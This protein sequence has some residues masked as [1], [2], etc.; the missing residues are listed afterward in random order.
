LAGQEKGSHLRDNHLGYPMRS[1]RTGDYLYIRNFRP[2]RWP[3][4]NPPEAGKEA[5]LSRWRT[6]R[7]PEEMFLVSED[8]FCMNNLAGDD[9]HAETLAELRGLLDEKLREQSDPRA[10]GYGDIYEG[11][12]RYMSFKP[13]LKGFKE[14]GEYNPAYLVEVP[15]EILVS[16]LYYQA[17]E[18]KRKQE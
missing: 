17:L 7:Q 2:E 15:P 12:P 9:A 13:E 1:I 11:F 14:R 4:G 3:T 5:S 6:R 16:D 8:P 10:L 18:E